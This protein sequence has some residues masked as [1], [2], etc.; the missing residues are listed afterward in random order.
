MGQQ[1]IKAEAAEPKLKTPD[2]ASLPEIIAPTA[3]VIGANMAGVQIAHD[4]AVAGFKVDVLDR[5]AQVGGRDAHQC[6][7]VV[8]Y[9]PPPVV[10]SVSIRQCLL[11]GIFPNAHPLIISREHPLEGLFSL[12]IHQWLWGRFCSRST[13]ASVEEASQ[14]LARRS[15]DV[16]EEMMTK[17]PTLRP[18]ARRSETGFFLTNCGSGRDGGSAQVTANT[19]SGGDVSHRD[20]QVSSHQWWIDPIRWTT[21]LARLCQEQ[22]GVRFLLGERVVSLYGD[23]R[24][25][26]EYISTVFTSNDETGENRPRLYD[27]V[28]VAAGSE[29]RKLVA[30]FMQLPLLPMAGF[31]LD[32]PPLGDGEIANERQYSRRLIQAASSREGN[33]SEGSGNPKTQSEGWATVLSK[34]GLV[35]L[36]NQPGSSPACSLFGLYSFSAKRDWRNSQPGYVLHT[37]ASQLRINAIV[38]A[39]GEDVAQVLDDVAKDLVSAPPAADSPQ[40]C[41]YVRNVTPDGLPIASFC[42]NTYNGFVCAG[43]GGHSATFGPGTARLLTEIITKTISPESSPVSHYRLGMHKGLPPIETRPWVRDSFERVELQVYNS[44]Q[45]ISSYIKKLLIEVAYGDNVVP[46]IVRSILI[47]STADAPHL[48]K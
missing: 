46:A 12:R 18:F 16:L 15:R 9:V 8:G 48:R 23:V 34:N 3:V 31:R 42:G 6:I 20:G 27:V 2:P 25:D 38:E 32:L 4:L 21:E 29:T 28:V 13:T 14:L 40:V 44:I 39:T 35:L 1:Q 24:K 26:S 5:A 33:S 41:R 36:R 7:P 47:T 11:R 22:H 45:P 43:F 17:Y 30:P 19:T 10:V 37:L